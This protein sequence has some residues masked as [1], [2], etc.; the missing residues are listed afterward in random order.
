MK[1]ILASLAGGGFLAQAAPGVTYPEQLTFAGFAGALLWWVL[2]SQSKG[3]DLLR[4][5]VDNQTRAVEEL[6]AAITALAARMDE[7]EKR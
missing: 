7:I 6:R 2:N 4:A 3:Q 1:T 5:A